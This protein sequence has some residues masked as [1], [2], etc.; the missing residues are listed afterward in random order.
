MRRTEKLAIVG[1]AVT[2]LVLAGNWWISLRNIHHLNEREGWVQHTQVVLNAC[3]SVLSSLA[4]AAATERGYLLSGDTSYLPIHSADRARATDEIRQL[5]GLLLDN[6]KQLPPLAELKSQTEKVF[7]AFDEGIKLRSAASSNAALAATL[8]RS[9]DA[10]AGIRASVDMLQT[11]EQQLLQQRIAA[12]KASLKKALGTQGLASAL[13]IVM[14]IAA[15]AMLRRHEIVR[16]RAIR[17]WNRLYHYNNLLVESTGE[18]IYGVD[19]A[20]KCTFLNAAGAKMLGFTAKQVIGERMH[21]L[22]HHSHPDGTRYPNDECPI[23]RSFR[24]RTGVRIDNEVFWRSDGTSFPVE[25]SASP[26]DNEGAVD[27][28]VVTFTDITV[29][30]LAQQELQRAK[31]DAELASQQAEAANVAKSQFLAN[32]SHELRT[33]LNA[34]I[35][36]SELLKEEAEDRH[37]E[38]FLPDLDKIRAAGK[39]LL[40][41]VNGVLDLSKIEAGKMELYLET[42]EVRDMVD[43]VAATVQP[44]VEKKSNRL[45]LDIPPETDSVHAD[46]TKVRQV[47]FNLLSNACKFTE[48]GTVRVEAR[49]EATDGVDWAVFRVIDS[50]IGM[51]P[52]QI[53]RLFQPFTQ[54]DASTTRKYGGTG[55][56]LAISKR[57]AEIM[58][59]EISVSSEPG[60]GSTFVFRLPARVT[61]PPPLQPAEI[62]ATTNP[63]DPRTVATVLVVDD[64]ESVRTLMSRFLTSDCPDVK[65]VTAA[66]GQEGLSLARKLH[67]DL[68]FLDVLMPKMDGWAV[69]TALK[70][71][72]TLAD[73]PV[74]MLTIMNETEMGYV[75][76]ASEYLTKPI[77]RERLTAVLSKYRPVRDGDVVLLV[78]DDP[79]TREVLH[80]TL[81]RQ[82]WAVAEAENGRVALQRLSQQKPALILLDLMMPE[83]DGFEFLEQLRADEAWRMIPVVVL[84][85]KDL[86]P[87]ERDRLS[88][89]VER[90]LQKGAYSREAL[91][92][93]VRKIVAQ[94]A[95][96]TAVQKPTGPAA[97]VSANS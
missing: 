34:V 90:I 36:Y 75:L 39:H 27:G 20:G 50:G 86:T 95:V 55:L 4:D 3:E 35:M 21:D 45:E 79:A 68:I 12:S 7:A 5:D 77:D 10:M 31:E 2:L 43:E 46:L 42:F 97:E 51:S 24:T 74:V 16:R 61:P 29:R 52:E 1:V 70:A 40:A 87:Q 13:A 47:L 81:A 73:I 23:Y 71:D 38:E 62:Q 53:T 49:R 91:L 19:L 25:Y 66:D 57:F 32:M 96:K 22:T 48:H 64:E 59:G 78:E 93:E 82:N 67:P 60:K 9:R 80:R 44:L 76:G 17:E 26:I 28:A 30:K 56:G 72:P 54:A 11:E 8:V 69:L 6:P 15:Y 37:V 33:P 85:S 41:L 58:G 89:K 18:G 94:C 65:A 14:V 84:T 88:G 83:M 92:R 63:A